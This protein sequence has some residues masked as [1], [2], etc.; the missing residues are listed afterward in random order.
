MASRMP[1]TGHKRCREV[2]KMCPFEELLGSKAQ[3]T[4]HLERFILDRCADKNP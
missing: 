2:P 1:P 4:Y 3:S